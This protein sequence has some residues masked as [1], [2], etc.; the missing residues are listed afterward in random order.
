RIKI[1]RSD[2]GGEF[3]SEEFTKYC[4]HH[5]IQ[6]QYSAPRTPQQNGVVERKNRTVQEMART[7]LTESKLADKYWKE[8]IHTA[9][10]IQNRC[11]IRPHENKTPYE[12]WFGRKATVKH[13]RVFGSKCYIKRLEQNTGKFE[14]R[15][16]EG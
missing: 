10:Y 8:A 12:L 11:L 16:D 15:A 7:M 4:E 9:V 6:R 14:E 5:G 2:R 3:T 1:L 13:F